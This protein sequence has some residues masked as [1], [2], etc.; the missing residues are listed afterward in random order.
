ML[1][2]KMLATLTRT[3]ATTSIK[4]VLFF[5]LSSR[6]ETQN[7]GVKK[8]GIPRGSVPWPTDTGSLFL[9]SSYPSLLYEP[10]CLCIQM[11]T[12]YKDTNHKFQEST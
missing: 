11:S 7:G 12:S 6:L 2:S 8:L 1:S 10:K 9:F 4:E 5:S 3:W